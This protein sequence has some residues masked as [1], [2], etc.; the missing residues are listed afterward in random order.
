VGTPITAVE[1]E[2]DELPVETTVF[3][4]NDSPPAV[5]ERRSGERHL[6]LLRVGALMVDGRRELC[7][8]KN[9][10][11]GG[12]SI[13]AYCAIP[14]GA[15][16][17]IEL[18]HGVP[19]RGRVRWIKDDQVGVTFD[20]PIDILELLSA[21]ADG[22]RPRMPRIEVDCLAWVREGAT[23]HRTRAVNISQGGMKVEAQAQISLRANVTVTL[24]GLAP[25]PGVVRWHDSG[26]YGIT[27]DRVI[28]LPQLVAWL[29]DQRERLRKAS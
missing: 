8:I 11:A 2:L 7:L 28:A 18:K 6:S 23:V 1:A 16:I 13:R 12:M 5:R 26:A 14:E 20:Q 9:I 3:S 22:P 21:S 4:L 19:I 10:S 25:Q 17:T 24:H 15:E 29:Q 27:F